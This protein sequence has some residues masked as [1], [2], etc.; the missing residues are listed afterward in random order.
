MGR[1]LDISGLEP[2]IQEEIMRI[3]SRPRVVDISELDPDVQEKINH[4]VYQDSI[5][6]LRQA[7]NERKYG[8]G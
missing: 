1:K 4:I 2:E 3:V 6:I 5:Q 7:L 8:K